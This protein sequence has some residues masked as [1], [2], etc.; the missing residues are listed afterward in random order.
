MLKK[1][2]IICVVILLLAGILCAAII[3][4]CFTAKGETDIFYENL[5]EGADITASEDSNQVSALQDGSGVWTAKTQGAFVE[6]NFPK[7]VKLNTIILKEKTDHVRLFT[8]YFF[9]G[10][11]YELLYR[12]DRIDIF[13][14]CATETIETSK[15]KIVFDEFDN[16]IEIREI[17]VAC[18][19]HYNR[20]DFKVTSY[21]TSALDS[22][23]G[24]TQ[25]QL[26]EN[27]A[28]FTG[29]FSVLTDVIIIGNVFLNEDGT[30]DCTV[31]MEN[32]KKDVAI[33]K[34]I[35]PDMKV[36]CTLMTGLV[37]GDFAENKRAIVRFVGNNLDTY[38]KNLA[39]FVDETG[40]DG[41]DFDW[42]YP[43]LP[44]EW[45]AYS[46]L[47]IAS[48]QALN[49][50]DLSV[51]LWPYGAHL[52]KT[53]RA[54][55]DNVNIMAYDQFDERGD[56]SSIYECGQKAIDYFLGLGFSKEQLCLGIPFYGRTADGYAIWP[57]YDA[58]YGKWQ[59][60]RENFAYQDADG[61]QHESTVYLN[62]YAMVRDKTA[63]ALYNDLGGIMI[64]NSN[65]DIA[66]SNEFA[67]HKAVLEVLEQRQA[68]LI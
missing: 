4:G 29:R 18:L 14:L 56:Q 9:N 46:K 7:M 48:K 67:L 45:S 24:K 53:A 59:N 34:S 37:D 31:G 10:T 40:I 64:F 49:G 39:A 50:G 54:C 22:E 32:F 23:T 42:E 28:D 58:D 26:Q 15:L 30:I 43:Q 25:I 44:H 1:I 60:Y 35:N 65:C 52:S 51:A 66:Y 68:Y 33:L 8:I 38:Q 2:G 12:Q 17:G 13:R 3:A 36:R 5:I 57:S 62:G 61:V 55:I 21:L 27:D 41:I 11:D 6:I 63:L 20:S 47:L 16:T 19:E